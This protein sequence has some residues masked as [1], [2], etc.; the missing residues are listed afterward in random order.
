MERYLG[1][2][3]DQSLRDP[4]VLSQLETLAV[5][6]LGSRT[7]RL[8]A[9]PADEVG[10]TIALL[11]GAMAAD[12]Y[13]YAHLFRYIELLVVYPDALFR[14]STSPAT[15][16][17]AVARGLQRGIPREQLSF[18]PRTQPDAYAFFG[19][20]SA[21]GYRIRPCLPED[22]P[23]VRQVAYETWAATYAGIIPEAVQRQALDQWYQVD[24][25]AK[26]IQSGRSLTL[27]LTDAADAVQGF[28]TVSQRQ[29][30]G[31]RELARIYIRPEHQRRGLGRR[32]I[33]T[34]LM[35]LK[36]TEPVGRLYVQVEAENG[37]GRQAYLQ[38]GFEPIREYA[39]DLFG[40]NSQMLELCLRVGA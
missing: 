5:R 8:I 35:A 34:A 7:H 13:L 22:A 31:C 3:I 12:P 10:Q 19:L 18:K 17:P 2:V 39:S 26:Q 32:L 16:G 21:G 37:I 24:L 29:E 15:W 25:L 23:A 40:H 30:E 6:T 27:V 28:C 33:E 1:V 20:W 36:Q 14:I 38:M 4:N 11:Q 9:V